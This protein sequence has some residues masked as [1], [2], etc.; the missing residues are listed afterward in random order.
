MDFKCARDAF[1]TGNVDGV[2]IELTALYPGDR[3][4]GRLREYVQF[5]VSGGVLP[6]SEFPS[7]QT[8]LDSIAAVLPGSKRETTRSRYTIPRSLDFIADIDGVKGWSVVQALNHLALG[9]VSPKHRSAV[10]GTMRDDGIYIMEWVAHYRALGFDHIFIYTNDNADSSD[11]LFEAL[12]SHGIITV[13]NSEITGEV[14]PEAKAFGHALNLLTDLRDYEWALFV[15]SDEF[16][17]L[18]PGYHN[19]IRNVLAQIDQAL[20]GERVAGICYDWLWFIS[21]MV[22]ERK[23]GLLCERFQHARPHWLSKC[24]VRLSEVQ[25]MRRQHYPE[26]SPDSLVVDSI[27]QPLNIAS[28]WERRAAQYAGG[29]INH[30]WPRSFQEFAIKKARGATLGPA[31]DIYDRPYAKFFSWNGYSTS[32]NFFPTDNGLLTS[33]K[34]EVEGMRQLVD[35]AEAADR[36][37]NEFGRFLHTVASDE[38][39]RIEYDRSATEPEAL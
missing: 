24:L 26:V 38:R 15:D 34:N 25:S 1:A 17:V 11:A 19:S 10:V 6:R 39:L 9:M 35:V 28:I 14:P 3:E 33:T 12:A 23:S 13:L 7:T 22:F 20:P 27:F 31:N 29:R 8:F 2:C 37:R 36:I 30:Y 4:I 18:A 21:D 32:D 16:L 5:A